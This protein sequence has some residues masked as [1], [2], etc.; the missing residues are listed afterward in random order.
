[1]S[2]DLH[3]QS[4]AQLARSLRDGK[5]SSAEV[6]SHLLARIEALDGKVQSFVHVAKD[7]LDQ[8]RASDKRRRS[9]RKQ[10]R[11]KADG[12]KHWQFLQL[13]QPPLPFP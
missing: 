4:M 3:W 5:T 12:P 8:A 11:G 10:D 2:D 13:I 1:M 6:T 9:G 7:A